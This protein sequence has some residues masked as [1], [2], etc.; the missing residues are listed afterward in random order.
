MIMTRSPKATLGLALL[1]A[2]LAGPLPSTAPARADDPPTSVVPAP[3]AAGWRAELG[4]SDDRWKSVPQVFTFNNG[5]EPETL[6]PTLMTGVPEHRLAGAIFEGLVGQHPETLQPVPGV[7]ER[8]EMS[9]DGLVYTFHLRENAMWSNGD[10]VT[11]QDFAGSWERALTPATAS[12]YAYML[13]PIKN[14]EAFNKVGADDGHGGKRPAV[15]FSD[16]GVQVVDARTLRVTLANPC[17]YFL[18]LVAFETLMP[19]PLE[20]VKKFGDHWTRP[21]N[22]VGN[23][24]F[25]VKEWLPNQRITFEKSPRYWDA[26]NVHLTRVVALPYEDNETAYK[27]FQQ[28]DCDWLSDVPVAKIDECKRLPEF[29]VTPYLGTYFYRLNVTRPPL[30]DPRVRRALSMAIDRQPITRD[31][32]K[33]GQ[34][35]ATWFCPAMPGYQPPTGLA[36]NRD[37]ARRL[38]AEAGFP[39]GKGFPTVELLY[40]TLDTHKLIAENVVQQWRENLGITVS[41][42]NS[43]WKVYLNDVQHL[44]YS[45]ARAAWIGDYCD[46]NT[47][48][49]MFVTDG[50]NNETGWSNARYDALIRQA[51]LEVDP[52]KRARILRDAEVILVEQE[53]PI[54]PIYIYV[55]K[56]LKKNKVQGFFENVRDAHPFQ[57]LWIEPE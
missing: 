15:P 42:R 1:G 43:E 5:A 33:A 22:I 2:I 10:K 50:G 55:N 3:L 17:A 52:V 26:Q 14:A 54:I 46:P 29:Y 31:L 48:L 6:D 39:D 45:M 19:V 28:G 23:G 36:F 16:V 37:E 35:P 57:Y 13:Y 47:F 25:T 49:D 8:W 9:P 38:L 21:E 12:Q 51:G 20:V 40:N 4:P 24:P 18:D 7:A 32:L 53:L 41:L 34:V 27:L 11:A 30:N 56:G 44:Q